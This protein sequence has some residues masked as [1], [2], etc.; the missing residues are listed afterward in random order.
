MGQVYGT[1]MCVAYTEGRIV[2]DGI[3]RYHGRQ[4]DLN[5]W[6]DRERRRDTRT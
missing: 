3:D 5:F 2:K 6:L 1:C 4:V